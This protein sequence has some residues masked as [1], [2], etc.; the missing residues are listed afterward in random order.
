[1][2]TGQTNATINLVAG[3]A[4]VGDGMLEGDYSWSTPNGSMVKIGTFSAENLDSET[5]SSASETAG[6]I[7]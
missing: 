7:R 4:L 2:L 1:M 5:T 6:Q 3:Q